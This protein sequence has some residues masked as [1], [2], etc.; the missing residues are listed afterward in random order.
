ML[1]EPPFDKGTPHSLL[2]MSDTTECGTILRPREPPR[3]GCRPIELRNPLCTHHIASRMAGP[4]GEGAP[5]PPRATDP[6]PDSEKRL[7]SCVHSHA[8]LP[9][10]GGRRAR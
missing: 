4:L 7:L 5:S 3:P 8:L 2:G 10:A 9:A 6:L 1:S